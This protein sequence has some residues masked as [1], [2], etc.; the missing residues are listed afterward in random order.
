MGVITA[1]GKDAKESVNKRNSAIDFKKVFI[2]L[3][4][5]DS[6]RVRLL[7]PEDYVEYRAHGLYQ[8]GIYT[9]P[10]IEPAGQKCAHCEAAKAGVEEFESL[11]ARKRYLFAM[12]DID[13]GMVRIFD[14]SQGQAHGLIQTIEQY[15]ED[16]AELAFVFKRTG[17]KVDTTFTL[18]PIIKLKPDD[19]EKFNRFDKG[20]VED[21]IY[22][23][24]L[25]PRTRQ[26]QIEEL[27][28][29]GFPVE[30]CFTNELPDAGV[31]PIDESTE[32]LPF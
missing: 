9:Q 6:V 15:Q 32:E 13:E 19:R 29:A 16:L 2:R 31:T 10:C 26:Q 17:T 30:R 25:Q 28:K 8:Q 22:E 23:A 1:K 12:A 27:E 5:G 4:D 14:A 24:V 20:A 18:N 21:E 3:K 11:R 7:S